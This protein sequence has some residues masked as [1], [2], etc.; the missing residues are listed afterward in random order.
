MINLQL[1]EEFR[2]AGIKPQT[3]TEYLVPSSSGPF[4]YRS[5]K[6]LLAFVSFWSPRRNTFEDTTSYTA[7]EI[8]ETM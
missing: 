2:M 5:G 1:T 4:R 3:K 7:A 6:S 8:S